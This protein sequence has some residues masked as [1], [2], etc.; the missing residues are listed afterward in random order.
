M[1]FDLGEPNY[2]AD[3]IELGRNC[4]KTKKKNGLCSPPDI[5]QMG[6]YMYVA[7]GRFRLQAVGAHWRHSHASKVCSYVISVQETIANDLREAQLIHQGIF[8]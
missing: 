2:N 7:R 3:A 4:I 8:I 6:T 1:I 5:Y